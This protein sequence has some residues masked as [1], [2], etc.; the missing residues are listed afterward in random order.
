M[1]MDRFTSLHMDVLK[2]IGNIGAG[3]AATSLSQILN[4]KIEMKVP[5]V[6]IV[7]FDEMMD[8]VGG[9]E[10]VLVAVFLRIE[11]DITGSMFFVL[12]PEEADRFVHRMT[13]D[14][15]FT[16]STSQ[17]NEL[18][19]S[20]FQELGNIVSGSYLT[21]LSDFTRLNI[22]PSVPSVAVDMVG[23]ILSIGLIELSQV[24]DYAIVVNTSLMDVEESE[25]EVKGHFFL[26]PDPNSFETIFT[27]LGV[28]QDD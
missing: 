27:A 6:K 7:S 10:R 16:F 8:I 22:Q 25:Q 12:S 15:T 11:G 20:A 4:R 1:Y 23:A 13:G 17:K 5:A 21:S 3:N 18:A 2:E 24:S 9:P 26:L 19:I 28:I 14:E